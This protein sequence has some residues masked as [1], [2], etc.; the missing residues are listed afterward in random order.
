M[1]YGLIIRNNIKDAE[2]CIPFKNKLK[3]YLI[4]KAYYNINDYLNDKM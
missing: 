4:N 2:N 1:T 3:I